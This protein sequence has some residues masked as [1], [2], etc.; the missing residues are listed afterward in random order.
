MSTR[1]E[2]RLIRPGE[3]SRDTVQ[4]TGM[5][6]ETAIA[7]ERLWSGFVR[8]APGMDSGWHHHGAY[9]T[10]IYMVSGRARFEFGAGGAVAVEAG[11]GDFIQVPAGA[12]HRES[13][14]RAEEAT[15]VVTRAGSGVPVVNVDGPAT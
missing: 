3:R 8:A 2:L 1:A 13:N 15:F 4:T 14:P 10:S 11:P 7:S 12:V 5:T 9:E 6:R